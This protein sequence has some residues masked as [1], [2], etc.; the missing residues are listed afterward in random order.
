MTEES[1]KTLDVHTY[2]AF[3]GRFHEETDRAAAVL[4]G[5]YLDA[6]M[7][8]ALRS[9]LVGGARL[10]GLFEG[11]GALRSLGNKVSLARP[12]VSSRMRSQETWI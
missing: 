12:L 5:G 2:N 6:F 4:A 9:I 7:E 11:Q 3:V 8:A 10:D 1:P